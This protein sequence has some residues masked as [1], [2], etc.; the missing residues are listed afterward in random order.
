[1]K[2]N[3]VHTGGTVEGASSNIPEDYLFKANV[4]S[5]YQTS[6]GASHKNRIIYID[7]LRIVAIIAVIMIHVSA[8]GFSDKSLSPRNWEWTVFAIYN[9]VVRFAVP[10][11]I[12]ITGALYGNPFQSFDLRKMYTKNVF[13]LL[14]AL[15]FW[16]FVYKVAHTGTGRL[17]YLYMCI[18]LYMIMPI[19]R[20]VTASE[21]MTKYFIILSLIFTWGI[22][23]LF[24]LPVGEIF[25]SAIRGTVLGFYKGFYDN[26]AFHLG[27]GYYS[28]FVLGYV[29]SIIKIDKSLLKKVALIGFFGFAYTIVGTLISSWCLNSKC[30]NF[31][32]NQSLNVM[33][34]AIFIFIFIR[35]CSGQVKVL[36][37]S[38]Y[39]REILAV[40]ADA[41]FGVYLIH[42]VVQY[43]LSLVIRPLEYN[44][45]WM[46]FAMML[47]VFS[48]SLVFSIIMRKIPVIGKYIV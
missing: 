36:E 23:T 40:V 33:G 3:N 4:Q 42:T 39:S 5:K 19:L 37:I 48:L 41:V 15:L 16:Y 44:P 7:I 10:V 24:Q 2:Y 18:S 46:N 35:Y 11:F 1:M 31:L 9:A 38:P 17:W 26:P 43:Y 20:M 29:C 12:M 8:V 27:F 22:P 25:P 28:Y 34:E 45:L 21:M 30:L 6:D 13:R 32:Q 47:M 14:L